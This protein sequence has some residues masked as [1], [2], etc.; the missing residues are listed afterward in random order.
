MDN[1]ISSPL[2]EEYAIYND[3]IAFPLI[4][5]GTDKLK[6]GHLI[7]R[8]YPQYN[9]IEL[10]VSNDSSINNRENDIEFMKEFLDEESSIT[11]KKSTFAETVNKEVSENYSEEDLVHLWDST[12]ETKFKFF[13]SNIRRSKKAEGHNEELSR[14]KSNL[15]RGSVFTNGINKVLQCND[16]VFCCRSWLL[17]KTCVSCFHL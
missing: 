5:A 9:Q 7:E 3:R 16:V 11:Y 17:I 15:R 13:L 12:I 14:R 2:N 10:D 6:E 8:W 1:W 4:F